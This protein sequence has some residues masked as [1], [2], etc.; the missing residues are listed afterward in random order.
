MAF[1]QFDSDK[2]KILWFSRGRGRGHAI[3]DLEIWRELDAQVRFVSYGT[4]ARTL[5]EFGHA[6]IDLDLPDEGSITDV[7]VM[8]GKLVGWLA[9]DLVVSHEEFPAL[10]AAKIFD[11]PTVAVLDFFTTPHALSMSSLRYADRVIFT[12]HAG[13]YEEPPWLSGRVD[14]VG[15]VLRPFIYSRSDRARARG[16]LALDEKAFVVCVLPGSWTEQ[17]APIADLVLDAFSR[18]E[19]P[20]HLLWVAGPNINCPD[21]TVVE[22]DWCIERLMVAADVAVTKVN[23]ITLIELEHL[24]IPSIS[25]SH[26]LNAMDEQRAARIHSNRT[27]PARETS[28]EELSRH[29]I[30]AA[31]LTPTPLLHNQ[32]A[33]EA[34][35]LI[36]QSLPG[37][38][39]D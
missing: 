34:A 20:K 26:G 14:Y 27:L 30:E 18:I 37:S 38:L 35:R 28:G 4:G 31:S 11:K 2:R 23:R 15:P 10:P 7:T 36:A 12:D 33:R 21:V 5:E 29:L 22:K 1:P 25:L 3:P 8:A 9:P 16:E 6:V 17:D 32:S 19:E 39:L 24:G 13:F